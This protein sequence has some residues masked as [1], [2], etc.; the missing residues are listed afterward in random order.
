MSICFTEKSSAYSSFTRLFLN[1]SEPNERGS[2]QVVIVVYDVC[3]FIFWAGKDYFLCAGG[4]LMFLD[5]WLFIS[6]RASV[7]PTKCNFGNMFK[8]VTV[9]VFSPPVRWKLTLNCSYMKYYIY[10]NCNLL[11]CFSSFKI[12]SIN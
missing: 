5:L 7:V 11:G 6:E 12:I 2:I 4:F 10:R 8:C 3:L 9:W 1:E